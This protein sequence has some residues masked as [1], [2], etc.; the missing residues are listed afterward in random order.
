MLKTQSYA[1]P[2]PGVQDS[3]PLSDSAVSS[4]YAIIANSQWLMPS[5][6]GVM[7]GVGVSVGSGL[8]VGVGVGVSRGVGA[9][10]GEPSGGQPSGK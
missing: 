1:V 4:W 10:V 6:M 9:G 5:G 8:A 2:A 3:A 7:P